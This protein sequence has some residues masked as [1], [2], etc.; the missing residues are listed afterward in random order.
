MRRM[1]KY[2]L[3]WFLKIINSLH[4]TWN[5]IL[6]QIDPYIW[7]YIPFPNTDTVSLRRS[8]LVQNLSISI[9]P[10]LHNLFNTWRDFTVYLQYSQKVS[11]QLYFSIYLFHPPAWLPYIMVLVTH[12][13]Q[14]IVLTWTEVLLSSSWELD[15]SR[16]V[17]SC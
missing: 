14:F 3:Y 17:P 6:S 13:A 15:L 12:T 1:K 5:R 4:K 9:P 11:W 8:S 16:S 7:P 10:C 2:L